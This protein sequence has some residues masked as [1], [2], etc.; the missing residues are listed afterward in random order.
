MTLN[1]PSY[2]ILSWSDSPMESDLLLI[3]ENSETATVHGPTLAPLRSSKSHRFI[4][5]MSDIIEQQLRSPGPYND[6]CSH[7]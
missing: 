2:T 3:P 4:Y 7:C 6:L 1:F 5:D